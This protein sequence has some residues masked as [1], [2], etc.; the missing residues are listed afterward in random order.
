MIISNETNTVLAETEH[1]HVG[2]NLLERT[3]VL[4][5]MQEDERFIRISFTRKE[6]EGIIGGIAMALF[7]L[8]SS[9]VSAQ[10]TATLT[11]QTAPGGARGHDS[12]PLCEDPACEAAAEPH[13]HTCPSCGHGTYYPGEE[14]VL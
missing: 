11:P 10:I 13:G 7:E 2:W 14:P 1:G 3:V 9:Y 8:D 6:M 4:T 12:G 5:A